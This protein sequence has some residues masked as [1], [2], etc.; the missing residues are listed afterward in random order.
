[1]VFPENTSKKTRRGGGGSLLKI[2]T[3]TNSSCHNGETFRRLPLEIINKI[4]MTLVVISSRTMARIT[5]SS[6]LFQS[7]AADIVV[8]AYP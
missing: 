8:A 4:K 3:L 2:S 6:N 5:K 1:M 7:S